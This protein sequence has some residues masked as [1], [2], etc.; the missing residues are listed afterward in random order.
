VYVR[1]VHGKVLD[2]GHRGWLLNESF[3]FYDTSTDSLWLQATGEAVHGPYK[4][5]RLE[6]LPATHTTWEQWRARHPDTLVLGRPACDRHHFER[7]GYDRYYQTGNGIAYCRNRPL[8]LG[9]AAILPETQKLYP[10]AALEKAGAVS[11]ELGGLPVLVVYHPPSRTG[12]IF[13]RR[14]GGQVLELVPA[15]IGTEDVLLTDRRT[16]ASWSG[17]RGECLRGPARGSRL[18]QLLSTQ[19]VLENWR[20]HY[21][22]GAVYGQP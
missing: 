20:L 16:G 1:R 17:L 12:M 6:R 8:T 22:R 3:L 10:F 15:A 9:I 2:F 14:A 18:R 7:D 4:G 13:E 19:F 21:P 5:T 11:D